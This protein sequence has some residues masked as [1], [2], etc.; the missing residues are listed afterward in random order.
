M[1]CLI[2]RHDHALCR[3][4]YHHAKKET[5]IARVKAVL[6]STVVVVVYCCC[7]VLRCNKMYRSSG[8]QNQQH[9]CEALVLAPTSKVCRPL[10]TWSLQRG[11]RRSSLDHHISSDVS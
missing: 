4:I 7:I 1:T 3:P 10:F 9:S 11:V 5:R 2:V 8:Q 6:F